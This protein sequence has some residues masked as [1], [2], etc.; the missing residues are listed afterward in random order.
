MTHDKTLNFIFEDVNPRNGR[1]MHNGEQVDS[2]A[3]ATIK[4]TPR[5]LIRAEVEVY[6]SR[7]NISAVSEMLPKWEIVTEDEPKNGVECLFSVDG[8]KI[9]GRRVDNGWDYTGDMDYLA[10]APEYF[11]PLAWLD[12]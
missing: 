2:I 4:I 9:T 12:R 7:S 1:V 10:Y 8:I 3:S 5:D 11:I 6:L